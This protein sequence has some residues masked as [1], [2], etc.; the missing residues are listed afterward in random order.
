MVCAFMIRGVPAEKGFWAYTVH[1]IMTEWAFGGL[2][3]WI[4]F[5]EL[6]YI[7]FQVLTSAVA[8]VLAYKSLR[9]LSG[10]LHNR[11]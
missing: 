6:M 10:Q 5:K 3:G 7:V 2:Y 8:F 4:V 11:S 1:H 9:R